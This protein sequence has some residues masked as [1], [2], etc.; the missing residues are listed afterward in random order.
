MKELMTQLKETNAALTLE[1]T[2][3]EQSIAIENEETRA[4]EITGHMQNM[5]M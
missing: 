2:Y 4:K 3:I 1:I 5:L